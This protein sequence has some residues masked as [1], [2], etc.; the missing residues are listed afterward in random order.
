MLCVDRESWF[1][2]AACRYLSGSNPEAWF[3]MVEISKGYKIVD[4]LFV[5]EAL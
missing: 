1:I 3:A 4:S 5:E 2:F